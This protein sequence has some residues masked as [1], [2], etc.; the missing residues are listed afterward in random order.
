MLNPMAEPTFA[1]GCLCGAI[2]YVVAAAAIEVA[3]CHCASC[4]RASGAPLVTWA[5]FPAAAFSIVRGEP[6]GIR[7]SPSVRRTFCGA[8]GSSLTYREDRR[9]DQV[10]VTVAT[11]DRPEAL[12]PTH[13]VWTSHRLPWLMLADDLPQRPRDD[14]REA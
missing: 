1:G 9:A 4:R 11:L 7:S 2:R 12:P 14:V 13:H 10:D 5:T 8:C 6:R 3:H